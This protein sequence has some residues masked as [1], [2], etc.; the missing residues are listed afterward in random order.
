LVVLNAV[1]EGI[2]EISDLLRMSTVG[3]PRIRVSV[4]P[5]N[6]SLDRV[7]DVVDL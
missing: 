2:E 5:F 4:I 1:V 7:S 6:V 3:I